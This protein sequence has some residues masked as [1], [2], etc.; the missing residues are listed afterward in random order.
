M[1]YLG[2]DIPYWKREH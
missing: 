2:Y 1:V